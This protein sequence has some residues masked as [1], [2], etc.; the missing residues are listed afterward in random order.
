[1]SIILMPYDG[2][3]KL[4]AGDIQRRMAHPIYL[5][6][7]M[8][9]IK[10]T[11]RELDC[12]SYEQAIG[13]RRDIEISRDGFFKIIC[14]GK[15]PI[16]ELAEQI[17]AKMPKEIEMGKNPFYYLDNKYNKVLTPKKGNKSFNQSWFSEI[18]RGEE[19]NEPIFIIVLGEKNI[20]KI[21]IIGKVIFEVLNEKF[22]TLP[23]AEPV[24]EEEE[25]QIEEPVLLDEKPEEIHNDLLI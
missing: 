23:L 16:P 18:K 6:E 17:V 9:N 11:I 20:N 2:P 3:S 10:E 25:I 13:I 14:S 15:N 8:D 1:M 21:S 5:T 19:K 22:P 12:F 24:F 7:G 4:V